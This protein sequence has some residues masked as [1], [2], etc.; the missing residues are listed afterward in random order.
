VPIIKANNIDI[1]YK[2]TGHGE[3]LVMIMGL[4]AD[5]SG[6]N[7]QVPFFQKHYQVITF[8]HRGSGKSDKPKGPYSTK[9]MADD[10]IDLM[11]H[12]G[13]EK[14]HL[15][16]IS[17]GGMIAQEIAI[18]YPQRVMK[19]VLANTYACQ[20][21]K[22]NGS[23][24]EMVKSAQSFSR[25][26]GTTLVNLAFNKPLYRLITILHIRIRSKFIGASVKAADKVGFAGQL[27][28]CLKHNAL[29]RLP[30]IKSPTLVIT[31]TTDRVI[32]PSSSEVIAGMIPN[33]KLVKVENGS[34]VMN[35]EM[36]TV[37]NQEVLS[38]L[39][40]T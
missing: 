25:N 17:M 29:E 26:L 20:D 6:W 18:N 23:T 37:F 12:L 7:H 38:F 10:T 28:A 15:M 5:Q 16:G 35:M 34:H 19:L 21:S 36:R 24:L 27:E 14:A 2:I 1:N 31:G 8:D 4:G 3:P 13:I 40:N 39:N 22:S 32:K 33:A 30:L 11:D 9:M